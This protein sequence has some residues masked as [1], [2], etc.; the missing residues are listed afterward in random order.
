M[1]IVVV[2]GTVKEKCAVKKFVFYFV[3]LNSFLA[4]DYKRTSCR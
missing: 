4:A 3:V 2:N 1:F